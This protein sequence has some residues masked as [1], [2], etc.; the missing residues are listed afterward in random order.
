[1]PQAEYTESRWVRGLRMCDTA[2]LEDLVI[3]L[4]KAIRGVP[5]NAQNTW[6][7]SLGTTTLKSM[8]F[9][10]ETIQRIIDERNAP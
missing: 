5:F 8:N 1:M 3:T 2:D 10:L 4:N 7:E 6:E 9:Q